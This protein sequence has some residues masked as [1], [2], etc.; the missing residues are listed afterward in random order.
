MIRKAKIG[1]MKKN[2]ARVGS[3]GWKTSERERPRE[4]TSKV[5]AR[6]VCSGNFR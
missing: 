3:L 6:K 5:N 2:G 4:K 1:V